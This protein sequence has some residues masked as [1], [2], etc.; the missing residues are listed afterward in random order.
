MRVLVTGM[1]GVLGSRVAQLLEESPGVDEIVG[2]DFMPPRRRL[3]RSTFRRLDLEDRDTMASFVGGVAPEAVLHLA[4]AEPYARS[5]PRRA[6][7]RSH[8]T[9]VAVLGA[10]ARTGRLRRIVLRSGIEVYGRGR[11]RP[12]NPDELVVPEPGSLFG[13]LCLDAEWIATSTGRRLQIPVTVLRL[14]P[15]VGSHAPS[16]LGRLLRLPAVPVSAVADPPFC[17]L[18]LEDAARA[19]V[20]ALEHD[21]RGGP[22][23]VV[24]PGAATPWQAVR[25]GGR[26]PVPVVGPGWRLAR[27]MAE[28]AGAPIPSHVEELLRRGRVADGSRAP[29]VLGLGRLTSAPDILAELFAWASVS[30]LRRVVAA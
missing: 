22:L 4:I 15:V 18:H 24:G 25:L 19:F 28:V 3:R 27:W 2:F 30:P 21:E 5:S 20:A 11:G 16:P 12:S 17:L 1:G 29:E 14:A 8:T 9:T 23:N 13:H 10:A 7:E 26:I 6:V